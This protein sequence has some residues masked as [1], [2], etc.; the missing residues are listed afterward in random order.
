[1]PT[2]NGIT[3]SPG[4]KYGATEVSHQAKKNRST[5]RLD[6]SQAY[7]SEAGIN[8]YR[9]SLTLDRGKQVTVEDHF[10]LS[11]AEAITHHLMII[12]PAKVTQPGI[13]TI[14]FEDGEGRNRD[15]TLNYNAKKMEVSVEKIPLTAPE[16]QG[17]I[18]KWGDTIYRINFEMKEPMN[19]DK[20]RF[21]LK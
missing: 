5:M 3:Q 15:F 8:N 20:V 11:V 13:L 4:Q 16:D 17:I 2:I 1:L 18:T 7:P 9:R 19:K 6:I 10:E 14:P 12:F 21:V